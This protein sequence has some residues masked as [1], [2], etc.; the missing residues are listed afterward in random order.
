MAPK[1]VHL[2][3]GSGGAR[4]IAHIGVIDY[5][6]EHGY[7]IS[8]I[9]GCSM[10][11]VIGGM[12]A[13]G[14]HDDYKKWIQTLSKSHVFDLL[15]FTFGKIGFVKGE[16]IFDVMSEFMDAK[17]IEDCDIPFTA[18]SFDLANNKEVLF[19][20]GDLKTA[21][22]A[23]FAIPGVFTP[24]YLDDHIYVDGS[25]VNPLPLNVP[26]KNDDALVI[27]VSLSGVVPYHKQ[28]DKP[29]E[30][31]SSLMSEIKS[32]LNM[33]P[34][35]HAHAT[36]PDSDEKSIIDFMMYTYDMTQSRLVRMMLDLHKPDVFIEFKR[37]LCS[38]FEFHRAT[39]LIEK[40]YLKAESVLQ[41][42][43]ESPQ[44]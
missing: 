35:D 33:F 26:K 5:L 2:V 8:S 12:Y 36:K 7:T 15:D 28:I 18:V 4:G 11:A 42:S 22:R 21:L 43:S 31:E 19:D 20:N 44:S 24:L 32:W 25:V 3:L 41:K 10:G 37:D 27:A 17:R 38:V 34:D 14:Y 39:E 9:A 40:G 6:V 16:K 29:V 23:S 1:N 13:A 30:K